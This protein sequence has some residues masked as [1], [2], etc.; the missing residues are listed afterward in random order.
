MSQTKPNSVAEWGFVSE[1]GKNRLTVGREREKALLWPA[2][3]AH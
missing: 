1:L 2:H 3:K